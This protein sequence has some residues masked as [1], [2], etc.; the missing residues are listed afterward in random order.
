MEMK[1]KSPSTSNKFHDE[2]QDWD[3]ETPLSDIPAVLREDYPDTLAYF[4]EFL[5]SAHPHKKGAVCPFMPK[6]LSAGTLRF[7]F[8][9]TMGILQT[10]AKLR[11]VG[12]QYLDHAANAEPNSTVFV[13]FFE[14]NYPP[15]SLVTAQGA[16]TVEFMRA[17]TMVA[18]T[19]ESNAARSLHDDS[20][21]PFRTSLP[22]LIFRS[23]TVQDIAFLDF[24]KRTNPRLIM[25][26]ATAYLNTA[27]NRKGG[28]RASLDELNAVRELLRKARRQVWIRRSILAVLACA[29]GFAIY[30]L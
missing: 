1:R 13:V 26:F 12:E 5:V 28:G 27:T 23:M 6:V 29:I 7:F 20:F 25:T 22:C 10:V 4:E 3:A 15:K 11:D 16:I 9:E 17:Q 18:T 19:F 24:Q 8:M 30:S 14:P 21:Q 2:I